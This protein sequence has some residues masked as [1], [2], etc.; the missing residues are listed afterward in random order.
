MRYGISSIG[1]SFD[2]S[3]IATL[4]RKILPVI[5]IVIDK[6]RQQKKNYGINLAHNK[7]K[8]KRKK[9]KIR[10]MRSMLNQDGIGI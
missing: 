7:S 2:E 4:F 9:I 5:F 10:I 1:K 6:K 3:A 8:F